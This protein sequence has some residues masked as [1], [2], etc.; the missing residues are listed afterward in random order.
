MAYVCLSYRIFNNS[1]VDF[2]LGLLRPNKIVGNLVALKLTVLCLNT[3]LKK[4]LI[5]P[6]PT[7]ICTL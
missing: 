5:L 7:R 3:N 1:D 6:N 2:R 4:I